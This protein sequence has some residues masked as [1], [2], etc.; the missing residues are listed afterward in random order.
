M[1]KNTMIRKCI[2][3]YCERKGDNTWMSLY[4]KMVGNVGVIFTSGEL[5]AVKEKIKEFVVPARKP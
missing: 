2:K 3:D 5:D 1:G 4:E